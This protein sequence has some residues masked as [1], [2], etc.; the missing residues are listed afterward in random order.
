M[1]LE[2]FAAPGA[3]ALDRT[4]S[5]V[6]KERPDALFVLADPAFVVHRTRIVEFA[7][8]NRLPAMYPHREYAEAGGLMAYGTDLRDNYRRAATYV[9]KI[10][11]GAKA[12]DLPVEQPTKF[13][14]VI[15]AQDGQGARPDG[16]AIAAAAS[17]QGHRMTD[18][19]RIFWAG[20]GEGVEL[21]ASTG[22]GLALARLRPVS[23]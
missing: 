4:L 11:K 21:R 12:S 10:L 9:D 19:Q 2:L 17:G 16:P 7:K 13:E 5:A 23:G 22:P 18:A 14:L 3:D 8:Q 15:N 20:A 6:S 1:R